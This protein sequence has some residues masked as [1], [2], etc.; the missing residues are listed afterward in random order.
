MKKMKLLSLLCALCLIVS[1]CASSAAPAV[2]D[3]PSPAPQTIAP[4]PTPEPSDNP[5][6]TPEPS[7]E[8]TA[9]PSGEPTSEPSDEPTV[10]PSVEPTSDDPIAAINFPVEYAL[11]AAVVAITNCFADDIFT[12]D[13]NDYDITKFHSYAD[14]SGFYMHLISEGE[15][16]VK[17]ENI[18]HVEHL[19][20]N[21]PYNLKKHDTNVDISL[22][23]SFDG[24]SYQISNLA[25]RAPSYNDND[26]RYSNMSDLENAPDSPL[27]FIVSTALVEEE[28][29]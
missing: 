2:S 7:D 3:K 11:R 21:L 5:T 28:R 29:K 13:G 19:E 8:P 20:L 16:S 22:D 14:V 25:G 17:D 26:N 18:W 1:A 12:D 6:P 15:W 23:V 27:F 24:E 10:E 9:E 4:S